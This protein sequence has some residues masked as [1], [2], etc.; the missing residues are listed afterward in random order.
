MNFIQKK[1]VEL[2][3]QTGNLVRSAVPCGF[4]RSRNWPGHDGKCQSSC[5]YRY[6]DLGVIDVSCIQTLL[7]IPSTTSSR[8]YSKGSTMA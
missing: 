1:G 5:Y 8:W 3:V 2:S 4:Q 6:G 7:P